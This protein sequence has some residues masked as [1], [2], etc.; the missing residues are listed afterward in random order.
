VR[1]GATFADAAAEYMRWIEHDRARKPST[2]R[3][4]H[5]IIN[6]RDARRRRRGMIGA[7]AGVA[8]VVLFVLGRAINWYLRRRRDRAAQAPRIEFSDVYF[9]GRESVRGPLTRMRSG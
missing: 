8:A 2:V 7:I 9:A 4:Y 6:A 5:S 1:T 3:D